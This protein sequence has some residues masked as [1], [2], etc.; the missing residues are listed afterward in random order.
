MVFEFRTNVTTIFADLRSLIENRGAAAHRKHKPDQSHAAKYSS[1]NLT[2]TVKTK[3][4]ADKNSNFYGFSA[5]TKQTSRRLTGVFFGSSAAPILGTERNRFFS[6][7]RGAHLQAKKK[8]L[9]VSKLFFAGGCFCDSSP[10]MYARRTSPKYRS[11]TFVFWGF[12]NPPVVGDV[13]RGEDS[14]VVR[15]YTCRLTT[16]PLPP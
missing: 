12:L 8:A 13:D 11:P 3:L 9:S 10:P 15:A 6:R 5:V 1:K 16:S 4:F 7:T 14:Y 2:K